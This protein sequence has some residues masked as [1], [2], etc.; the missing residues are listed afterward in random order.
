MS[1]YLKQHASWLI[2]TMVCVATVATI[3]TLK[4]RSF[5]EVKDLI[6]LGIGSLVLLLGNMLLAG[7]LSFVLKNRWLIQ[8][9]S[10]IFNSICI[11]SSIY[12]IHTTYR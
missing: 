5:L 10:Y 4:D 7:L 9:K 12:L 11:L 8:R 6:W 1:Y 3:Y 2:G